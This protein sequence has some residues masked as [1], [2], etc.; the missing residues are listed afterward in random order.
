[1]RQNLGLPL[2]RQSEL[3]K[4]SLRWLWLSLGLLFLA[5][6]LIGVVLP[7]LPTTPFL[8][9]ATAA[10]AKSSPR[11]HAWLIAHPVLGPPIL[12]WQE[13]GAISLKAKKLAIGT[14]MVTFVASV[15]FGLPWQALL[16]QGVLMAIGAG[17]IL[18]RPSGPKV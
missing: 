18:T 4:L 14:M 3:G 9:V 12:N 17:V 2:A 15:Y 7:V 6:G 16:G 11:L 10:F 5:I 13:H 1:M 8:L